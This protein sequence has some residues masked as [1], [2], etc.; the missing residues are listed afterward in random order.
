[1]TVKT[2]RAIFG[3]LT[4]HTG[5]AGDPCWYARLGGNELRAR[6]I[7][8]TRWVVSHET[9]AGWIMIASGVTMGEVSARAEEWVTH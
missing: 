5:E 8:P 3:Q 9:P 1:M 6:P 7:A 4:W 2:H